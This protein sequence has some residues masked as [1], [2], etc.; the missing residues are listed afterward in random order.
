MSFY[1]VIYFDM[2]E[3]CKSDKC[4]VSSSDILFPDYNRQDFIF[5]NILCN[6]FY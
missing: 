3:G 2:G 1:F 4:N 6:Y 5:S